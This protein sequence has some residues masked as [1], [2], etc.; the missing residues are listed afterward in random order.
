MR[1]RLGSDK[2]DMIPFLLVILDGLGDHA[3]AQLKDRTPL[4][5]ASQANISALKKKGEQGLMDPISPGVPP[6][7]DTSHLTMFGYDL[8]TEYFGRGPI[9][10]AGEGV[11][12]KEGEIALRANMATVKVSGN[13]ATVVDRRAGRISSEGTRELA[14]LLNEEVP[15]VDGNAFR[16]VP[17]TE[18][19]LALIV[20]GEGLSH[21]V[22]DNDPHADGKA[23]L[24]CQPLEEAKDMKGASKLAHVLNKW[25]VRA[26]EV[27][28]GAEMNKKRRESGL[29]EAN[30]VL[31]RGAGVARRLTPFEEK[32]GMKASA[33]AGGALYKGVAKAVGMRLIEVPGANGMPDT[34]LRGKVAA[35]MRALDGSDFVF[36]HIKATD[37]FSHKK[38]PAGKA[39]FISSV[40]EH[41]AP[42]LSEF[43]GSASIMITGDHTTP[44][45]RGMHTGEPVPVLL[46]GPSIRVDETTVF[47]ER[48]AAR[49]SLGR[50]AGSSVV[51]IAQDATERTV[52]MGTRPSPRAVTYMPG[53]L[54]PLDLAK[55][56]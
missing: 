42:L 56:R 13:T 24:A 32:H 36:L 16:L 1:I 50:I 2:E 20:S 53:D 17:L 4:E 5:F 7:S 22:T 11:D 19:R 51:Q 28:R 27:L 41:L 54:L 46:S 40:D 8:R 35:S 47:S 38:D 10:A 39:S 26:I 25:E 12:L 44:C 43:V 21:Q 14:R 29:L 37:Y 49:G 9:E 15:E 3:Y 23:L 31:F 34:N 52:E 30:A 33:I 45:D 6:G 55:F 48:E 18:H